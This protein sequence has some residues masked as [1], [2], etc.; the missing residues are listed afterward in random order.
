MN[1]LNQKQTKSYRMNTVG[2]RHFDL[3]SASAV[4][5][6]MLSASPL[7]AQSS[8]WETAV[9]I[10]RPASPARSRGAVAR[11]SRDRRPHVRLQRRCGKEDLRG[12]HLRLGM[13]LAA[14]NFMTWLFP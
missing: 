6:A 4:V 8:P 7:L 3:R 14:D 12:H 2:R 1:D 13:A 10:C 9:K 11:R 5:W